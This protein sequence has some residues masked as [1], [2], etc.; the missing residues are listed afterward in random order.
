MR[1]TAFRIAFPPFGKAL[2]PPGADEADAGHDAL[3]VVL[4]HTARGVRVL[5][6]AGNLDHRE[7]SGAHPS[8][9]R[10]QVRTP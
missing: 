10:P 5:G 6:H 8:E 4:D 9:T 1:R 2:E 7:S 3:D